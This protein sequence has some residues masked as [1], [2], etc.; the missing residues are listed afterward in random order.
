MAQEY[1]KKTDLLQRHL[2]TTLT[3]SFPSDLAVHTALPVEN[4]SASEER[5]RGVWCTQHADPARQDS[6]IMQHSVPCPSIV[7]D[8]LL[9]VVGRRVPSLC[10]DL[11]PPCR[12]LLVR[13]HG[14]E[15][16]EG[17]RVLHLTKTV[18]KLVLEQ[19]TLVCE[20]WTS[21]DYY[22]ILRL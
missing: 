20:T 2:P 3:A 17:L 9:V 22:S 15:H 18:R 21:I 13:E 6:R 7:L 19:R 14:F 12:V 8:G 10:T 5:I 4:P 11:R 16:G 1:N